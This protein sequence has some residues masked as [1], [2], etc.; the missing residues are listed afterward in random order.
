MQLENHNGI[1]L[2]PQDIVVPKGQILILQR[3]VKTGKLIED[4]VNNMVVTAG[5]NAIADALRGTT[6]NNK[7]IITYCALGTGITAPALGNTALQTELFR[8]IISVRSVSGNAATFQ[9]FFTTAEG[10]GTLKEAGLFGDDAS[11]TP[12]SGTLFCR[13]AINRVKTSGD[14]LTLVWTVTIG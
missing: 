12:G 9:T 6:S 2:A 11:S 7:G 13:A 4:M 3:D 8:K 5:K 10:N 14:T 1:W